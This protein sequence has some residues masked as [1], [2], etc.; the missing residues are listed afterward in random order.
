VLNLPNDPQCLLDPFTTPSHAGR[1]I[2]DG[3][4]ENRRKEDMVRR[5]T[6]IVVLLLVIL[7]GVAIGIGAYNAGVNHG[8]AEAGHASQVV[9]VVEPGWGFPFGF[10]FFPLF[11][12]GILFLL[13]FAWGRRWGGPGRG[14]WEPGDWQKRRQGMF[15]DWHR[16]Q[17]QQAEGD[18]PGAGGEPTRV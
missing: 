8:L 17:H 13:R 3:N 1:T 15:E 5:V 16:R 4:V 10:L 2:G 12:F 14:H 9:R 18:H 6:A 11:F 7:G